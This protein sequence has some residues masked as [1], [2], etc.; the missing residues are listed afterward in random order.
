MT[1][2][3]RWNPRPFY[4]GVDVKLHWE[5]NFILIF[6]NYAIAHLCQYQI[7]IDHDAASRQQL[8]NFSNC[9]F[10][11]SEWKIKSNTPSL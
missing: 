10:R 7:Q 4:G 3:N 1:Y 6:F 2:L 5:V 9:L 11:V 8:F